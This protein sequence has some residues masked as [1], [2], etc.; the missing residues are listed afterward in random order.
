MRISKTATVAIDRLRLYNQGQDKP[1][2]LTQETAEVEQNGNKALETIPTFTSMISKGSTTPLSNNTNRPKTVTPAP[3]ATDSDDS[4][5]EEE[6]NGSNLPYLPPSPNYV[7]PS[8]P[9]TPSFTPTWAKRNRASSVHRRMTEPQLE[10]AKP[11]DWTETGRPTIVETGE[12]NPT[13]H[14]PEKSSTP[15]KKVHNAPGMQERRHWYAKRYGHR[16]CASPEGN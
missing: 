12:E 1:L 5:G 11:A 13:S 4:E 8:S 6:A 10:W 14:S 7:K 9:I 16:R 15:T 3:L 2:P